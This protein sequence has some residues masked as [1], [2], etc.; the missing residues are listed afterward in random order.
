MIKN[1]QELLKTETIATLGKLNVNSKTVLLLSGESMAGKTVACL[2]LADSAIK[3]NYKVLYFDTDEKKI[4]ARPL[5]NL[6]K[7]FYD[8]NKTQYD[9]LFIYADTWEYENFF[10]VINEQKPRLLIIDS[11]YQPFFSKVDNTRTRAVEIKKFLTRLRPYLAENSIGCIITTPTGRIVDPE[12]KKEMTAP[13]G[14]QG[15]K[16]LSDVRVIIEFVK[17]QKSDVE[18][19]DRRLFIID[20]QGKSAFKMGYGG[21]LIPI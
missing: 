15:I 5:P 2:H 21:H 3:N 9:S 7:E 14:G 19:T 20:R 12:T 8:K 4:F 16:L 11:L 1:W 17:D 13:L 18:I 10:N 6:F